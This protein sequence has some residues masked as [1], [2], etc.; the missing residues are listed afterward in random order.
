MHAL[1]VNS[2]IKARL[3]DH[4]HHQWWHHS[5]RATVE[6][7]C[8]SVGGNSRNCPSSLRYCR[9]PGR[10]PWSMSA[11]GHHTAGAHGGSFDGGEESP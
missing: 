9:Q 7:Q 1:T 3:H 2:W 11:Y 8:F 10:L 5:D 6:L 4:E